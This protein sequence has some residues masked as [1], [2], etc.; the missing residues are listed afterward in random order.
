MTG[1]SCQISLAWL[2]NGEE[3]LGTCLCM[4]KKRNA[5]RI[6]AGKCEGMR[7]LGRPTNSSENNIEVSL[8]EVVWNKANWVYLAQD[9]KKKTPTPANFCVL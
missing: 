2:I 4:G 1:I 5:Y 8:K 3:K 7:P 9:N 6:L